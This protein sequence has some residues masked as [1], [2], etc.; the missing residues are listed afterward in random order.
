MSCLLGCPWTISLSQICGSAG[1]PKCSVMSNSPVAE[2][3]C[4]LD[5]AEQTRSHLTEDARAFF[6]STPAGPEAG[7][8]GGTPS[9]TMEIY[10]GACCEQSRRDG[11][12]FRT[13][14]T[15]FFD[16]VNAQMGFLP[17]VRPPPSSRFSSAPLSH[18]SQRPPLTHYLQTNTAMSASHGGQ[19]SA[20]HL[21]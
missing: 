3:G 6:A 14:L 17:P 2:G 9:N 10:T 18:D 13:H 11:A 4:F 8:E 21:C 12:C 20:P 5:S 19:V 16:C 15:K 1:Y 7:Q